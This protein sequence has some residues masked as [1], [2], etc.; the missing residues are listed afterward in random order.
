LKASAFFFL[1]KIIIAWLAPNVAMIYLS[2]SI[3][4]L[5]FALFTPA[6]IYYVNYII[7]KHDKVKGQS[8]LGVAICLASAIA[9]ITGGRIL[10][11]IGVRNML[12]VGIA[13]TAVGFLIICLTT[14]K[15][16][17]NSQVE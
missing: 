5:G 16:D 3:Q 11:M 17:I 12:L 10:D 9:N 4:M 14:E 7:G 1:L 15:V 2:Q 8:M 13:V 6:S